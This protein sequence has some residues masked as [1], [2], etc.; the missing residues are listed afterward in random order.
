[1][2]ALCISVGA[3]LY[4]YVRHRKTQESMNRMLK[5]LETLQLAEGDLASVT[6]K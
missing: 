3:C 6:G 2:S 1:M 5:E 4:A